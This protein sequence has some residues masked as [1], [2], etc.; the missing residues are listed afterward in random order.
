MQLIQK[1]LEQR[2]SAEKE[3]HTLTERKNKTLNNILHR[4]KQLRIRM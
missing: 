1:K 3:E 4:T 2:N